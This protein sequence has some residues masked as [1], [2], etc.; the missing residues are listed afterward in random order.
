[1]TDTDVIDLALKAIV[2]SLKLAGPPLIAATSVGLVVSL[3][4]AVFQV[5]DQALVMVPKMAAVAL[6]IVICGPWMLESITEF[7]NELYTAI[8][9]LV[10]AGNAAG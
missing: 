8:P 6:A 7:V 10:N 9:A 4:Q 5:Q 2:L 1:M 3:L